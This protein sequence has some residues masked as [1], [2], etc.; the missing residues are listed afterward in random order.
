MNHLKT[1]SSRSVGSIWIWIGA[2]LTLTVGPGASAEVTVGD[3]P[4]FELTDLDGESVTLSEHRGDVVIVDIWA[5]WCDPCRQSMPF[6]R[7]LYD[8]RSD[9]GLVILAISV[10]ENQTAVADFRREHRL[11]FSVLVDN[12]HKTADAFSPPG[13]PTSYL[14][15]ADGVV[16]YR[17]V[18]FRQ[19]DAD[20]L[21]RYV[22]RL[23]DESNEHEETD[24]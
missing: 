8:E 10:D 16:R 20:K 14:I 15:D 5:T 3:Q 1:T 23:L 6:Y 13:M 12:D 24:R 19:N 17:H 2:L 9:D 11:P 22:D 18:G 21:E 4:D 7:R